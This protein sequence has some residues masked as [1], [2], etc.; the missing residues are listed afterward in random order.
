M[1]KILVLPVCTTLCVML[2]IGMLS[3][4]VAQTQAA[5]T[6]ATA[7]TAGVARENV[8]PKLA[9]A[10]TLE[11]FKR[12]ENTTT[13]QVSGPITHSPRSGT[14]S[15][16]IQQANPTNC[17]SQWVG[18]GSKSAV[19]VIDWNDSKSP[20]TI[21][22]GYHWNGVA[23]GADMVKAIS[24]A[25]PRLVF[26][27]DLG[28]DLIYGFA[29]D[30]NNNGIV[31]RTGT[32]PGSH[33]LDAN[34]HHQQGF[35]NTAFWAYWLSNDGKQWTFASTGYSG[36][37]LSDGDWDGWSWGDGAAPPTFSCQSVFL[38]LVRK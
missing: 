29:Y 31:G 21:V 7:A 11:G 18:T 35:S 5:A 14:V 15:L 19:L 24:V 17:V 22:L 25:D 28:P 23:T 8:A 3:P 4:A 20:E 1:K 32:Q 6:A 27:A 16:L 36:R 2:I 10:D 26:Y 13:A 38:P 9:Y 33:P 30:L 37:V 12:V 34:D